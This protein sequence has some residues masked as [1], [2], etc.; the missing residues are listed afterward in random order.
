MNWNTIPG[1]TIILNVH[2]SIDIIKSVGSKTE[3]T[4]LGVM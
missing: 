4:V 2:D 3:P 1:T